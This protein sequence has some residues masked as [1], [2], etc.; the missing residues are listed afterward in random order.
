[1]IGPDLW[2][3][4]ERWDRP[5]ILVLG[6]AALERW[7]WGDVAPTGGAG[8]RLMVRQ[9]EMRLA[10]GA[11]VCHL[12]AK[13]GADVTCAS[14][15]GGDPEATHVRDMLAASGVSLDA[16]SPDARRRTPTCERFVGRI[17]D[18]APPQ[19]WTV[20]DREPQ[21][22]SPAA[23]VE[24][25]ERVA[26]RVGACA[27][28]VIAGSDPAVCS[29]AVIRA[30][31]H[32]ARKAK[33]PVIAAPEANADWSALAGAT[34]LVL[35]RAEAEAASG[36]KINQPG[37]AMQAVGAACRRCEAEQ[38]FVTLGGEGLAFAKRH[39]RGQLL[40]TTA[41]A[42]AHTSGAGDQALAT[43]VMCLAGGVSGVTAG[44]LANVAAGLFVEH[45]GGRAVDRSLLRSRLMAVK[46]PSAGKVLSRDDLARRMQA[47]RDGKQRIVF[48]NGCFDL[49]HAG[50][51]TYLQEAA[52][53]GDV[54][55]VGLNSDASVRGLKGPTRPV[56][57]QEDRAALLAALS[58]VSYVTIFDEPT[59][60]ELIRAIRPDV[61][62]KGGDY[63]A[64]QVVGYDFVRSYGGRVVIAPLV[65][66]VSTTKILQSMAA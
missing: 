8:P 42:V 27:A 19:T 52:A 39:G 24:L 41:R 10:G 22:L 62:V 25:A 66:G 65:E 35:G 53:M 56:I 6:T 46:S 50:H 14:V 23:E 33:T 20:E 32:A 44:K 15:I 54:L 12:L 58:C 1:M 36:I 40:P 34:A 13:L 3:A 26:L 9:R 18:D 29:P 28:V 59:P 55:V 11:R 51:V 5:Q 45:A 61:L 43:A 37:D 60:A 16:I 21:T 7:T 30:A 4:V 47:C 31:V 64:E 17:A 49:L 48:T 2:N 57:R 38:A 63:Q